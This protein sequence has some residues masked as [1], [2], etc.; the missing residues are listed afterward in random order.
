MRASITSFGVWGLALIFSVPAVAMPIRSYDGSGNNFAH[1][2]WG[3]AG[4][5]LIRLSPAAYDDGLAVP[6]GG[7][8]A[9]LPSARMISEQVSS[10]SESTR[11]RKSASDWLWQWGQ[12][13]D[14]DLDL[15][16]TS[17]SPSEAFN[18]LVPSGDPSFDPAG[19]GNKVIHFH[20]SE[21]AYDP[22]GIRQQ[23]NAITA[24]IDASNV[25]GSDNVR[26]GILRDNEK[27]LRMTVGANGEILLGKNTLNAPNDNGGSLNNAEFFLA[28]DIRANEQVGLT[29]VH[30]LFAREHNR[31]VDEMQQRL[32]N[33]DAALIA[34]RDASI[35]A[36]GNGVNNENDFLYEAARKVVGAEIQKITYTEFLPVLLGT[37]LTTSYSGYDSSVNPGISNEFSSA[38]FR[39]GHTMLPSSLLRVGDTGVPSAFEQVQLRDAFF[40]PNE[41][42]ANGVDSLLRGLAVRE[43]QAVDTMLVDDVRNFLFGPPGAGGL[44]LAS[45]NIQRGR[46]HGL[47][48]LNFVR[49]ALGLATYTEF[50]ALTGGDVELA[51]ALGAVYGDIDDV[52]LWIGGLAE[53]ALGESMLGET[54]TQILIDQF[55]RSMLGDRFFY[56]GEEQNILN[57]LAPEFM[58]ATSLA[59]LIT[60][61]SSINSLQANVFLTVPEP[62]SWSLVLTILGLYSRRIRSAAQ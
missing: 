18:I 40:N 55:M 45:L 12:F 21:H 46:D 8:P 16:A 17:A 51:A 22:A 25:Y 27:Y 61:N 56:L 48:G 24:F 6:R 11:N 39:L 19:T 54:F 38:A 32:D 29:A 2:D 52:D 3:S 30:T 7:D 59:Q 14:H 58:S 31:L 9:V 43:A 41:V 50:E 13:L 33:G 62:A 10:Q 47:G 36:M 23:S 42:F 26:A 37:D 35:V 44:D 34:E 15:T 53:A 20:R 28:G 1:P 49:E 5:H 4:S 60:R 57:V